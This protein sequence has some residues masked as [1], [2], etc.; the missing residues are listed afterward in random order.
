MKGFS[1]GFSIYFGLIISTLTN[2]CKED[3]P[4]G[5]IILTQ[6][7]TMTSPE[8]VDVDFWSRKISITD[9]SGIFL[10]TISSFGYWDP[11]HR[12][13]MEQ[14]VQAWRGG[15]FLWGVTGP[16]CGGSRPQVRQNKRARRE[17]VLEELPWVR[18][19]GCRSVERPLVMSK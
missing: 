7:M 11:D 18:D 17:A 4:L 14:Q 8:L 10:K 19:H 1:G 2:K 9:L 15:V 3:M 12:L 5:Q 16:P 13:I 6:P